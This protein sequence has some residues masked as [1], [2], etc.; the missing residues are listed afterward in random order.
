MS[1]R[2]EINYVF[3]FGYVIFTVCLSTKPRRRVFS[4]SELDVNEGQTTVY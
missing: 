4:T 2:V 1:L 3:I